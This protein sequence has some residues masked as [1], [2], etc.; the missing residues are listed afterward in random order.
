MVSILQSRLSLDLAVSPLF[1]ECENSRDDICPS[2]TDVLDR[3][4]DES[5]SSRYNE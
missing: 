3:Y 5:S 2:N 1:D 4:D